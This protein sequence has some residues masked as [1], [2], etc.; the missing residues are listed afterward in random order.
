MALTTERLPTTDSDDDF[1]VHIEGE[2]PD[3]TTAR[4]LNL[5]FRA[6]S[7]FPHLTNRYKAFAGATVIV[8]GAL[9]ALAGVAVARR[10]K[11]GQKPEEALEALT[12]E[13]IEQAAHVG[14]RANRWW[15]LIG[16]IA[17]RRRSSEPPAT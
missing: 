12:A 14:S 6:A 5:A 13:E 10:M 3:G 2:A 15:R 17:R 9:M 8:S 4:T 16:R 1:M 7:K 11:R